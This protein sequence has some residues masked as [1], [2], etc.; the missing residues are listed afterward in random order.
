MKNL[1]KT[2]P[3]KLVVS[4]IA[5]FL[6]GAL[7]AAANGHGETAQSTVVGTVF[8]PAHYVAQKISNGIDKISGMKKKYRICN[9]KSATFSHSLLITK[10]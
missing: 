4:I 10:T 9:R 7:I 1:F 5:V 6:I 2:K 3:F 8:Y